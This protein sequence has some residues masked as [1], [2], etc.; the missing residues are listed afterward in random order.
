[1]DDIAPD[2]EG[3]AIG[4]ALNQARIEHLQAQSIPKNKP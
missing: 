1:M 3:P 4:E 2:L